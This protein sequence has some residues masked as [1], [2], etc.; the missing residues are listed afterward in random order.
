[1]QIFERTELPFSQCLTLHVITFLF[2]KGDT[3]HLK[4]YIPFSLTKTD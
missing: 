2:K 4:D 3:K 1:M